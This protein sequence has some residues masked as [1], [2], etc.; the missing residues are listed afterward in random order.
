MIAL[1]L[2]AIEREKQNQLSDMIVFLL[3]GIL[4]A[5]GNLSFQFVF[6]AWMGAVLYFWRARS[7]R[8]FFGLLMMILFLPVIVLLM[9]TF[10]MILFYCG[11]IITYLAYLNLESQFD[12]KEWYYLTV[13]SIFYILISTYSILITDGMSL[14]LDMEDPLSLLSFL[15][16]V[17]ILVWT[18]IRVKI[19]NITLI[20][21]PESD[22]NLYSEPGP[23]SPYVIG[24]SMVSLSFL[25]LGISG[26]FQIFFNTYGGYYYGFLCCFLALLFILSGIALLS[27]PSKNT[28]IPFGVLGFVLISGTIFFW[29]F[30][31]HTH[32]PEPNWITFLFLIIS[33][34]TLSIVGYDIDNLPLTELKSQ[35]LI[36]VSFIPLIGMG[37]YWHIADGIDG[38]SLENHV[39][40]FLFLG[41][42][43]F[44]KVIYTSMYLESS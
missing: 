25:A 17:I 12:K 7:L 8:V 28:S 21:S 35:L 34:I 31:A 16:F 23:F 5:L 22:K 40:A 30:D 38:F 1:G 41:T 6:V 3:G 36:V 19:G 20:A 2:P 27:I 13:L 43:I 32:L 14:G 4:L 9:S 37:I 11:V 39:Y 10:P 26:L 18:L 15:S 29:L 44:F 33:G 42:I 24:G